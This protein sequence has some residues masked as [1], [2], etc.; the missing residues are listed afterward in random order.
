LEEKYFCHGG[1]SS[2]KGR[3]GEEQ[4]KNGTKVSL[5]GFGK[6]VPAVRGRR[7]QNAKKETGR[8]L[9]SAVKEAP[10]KTKRKKSY[11]RQRGEKAAV[12]LRKKTE[13]LP[14]AYSQAEGGRE[15]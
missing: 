2:N 5:A 3:K 11:E 7:G 8:H 14:K 4:D 13:N 1:G 6:K 9:F 15:A 12:T 10:A